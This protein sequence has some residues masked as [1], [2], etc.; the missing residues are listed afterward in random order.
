MENRKD[1]IFAIVIIG[2]TVLVVFVIAL[3]PVQI[4]KLINQIQTNIGETT[5]L[6][7]LYN[8]PKGDL[9]YNEILFYDKTIFQLPQEW[10]DFNETFQVILSK[11]SCRPYDLNDNQNWIFECDTDV[12]PR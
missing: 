10:T 11:Q 3:Y 9:N 8:E 6:E 2:L 12:M 1:W 5:K 7:G 4:A